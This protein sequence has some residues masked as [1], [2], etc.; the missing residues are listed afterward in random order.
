LLALWL[1]APP[2]P[3]VPA[4]L[5]VV[6]E[7]LFEL[8]LLELALFEAAGPFA[9]SEASELPQA[10]NPVIQHEITSTRRASPSPSV[11]GLPC[12]RRHS[13]WPTFAGFGTDSQ[14]RISES[15]SR[16]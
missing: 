5:L 14:A 11:I 7:A 13:V 4:P 10:I 16:S 3:C 9:G 1:D 6:P 15:G 2:M 8:A 12:H